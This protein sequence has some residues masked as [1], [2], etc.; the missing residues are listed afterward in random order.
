MPT[1]DI[2]NSGAALSLSTCGSALAGA[3]R[4]QKRVSGPLKLELGQCDLPDVCG[5]IKTPVLSK[6]FVIL[7]T[8]QAFPDLLLTA[9]QKIENGKMDKFIPVIFFSHYVDQAGLELRHHVSLPTKCQDQRA[10]TT[11][12]NTSNFIF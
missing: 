2:S 4:V 1:P 11:T 8:E 10:C 6:S 5:G 12:P 9:L 3:C 7:P